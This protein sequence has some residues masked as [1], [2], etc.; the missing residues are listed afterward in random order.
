[1]REFA[2]PGN[3]SSITRAYNKTKE[4]PPCGG[5]MIEQNR[6]STFWGSQGPLRFGFWRRLLLARRGRVVF[7]LSS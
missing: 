1:M 3:T 6:E 5:G 4:T 2:I 7:G